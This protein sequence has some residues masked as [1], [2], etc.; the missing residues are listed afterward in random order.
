MEKLQLELERLDQHIMEWSFADM[1]EV[2]IMGKITPRDQWEIGG[3][4][5]ESFNDEQRE[6]IKSLID[7]KS[8]RSD[9]DWRAIEAYVRERSDSFTNPFVRSSILMY[10]KDEFKVENF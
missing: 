10:T 3:R 4:L 2:S 9:W 7:Q 8:G 6:Y 1:Q 5:W